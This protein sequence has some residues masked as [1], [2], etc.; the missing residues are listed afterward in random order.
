[1]N[2]A[3]IDPA[4][5]TPPPGPPVRVV[6]DI[7]DLPAAERRRIEPLRGAFARWV[8]APVD[9]RYKALIDAMPNR[10]NEFGYDEMGFN[11]EVLKWGL[12]F[13]EFIY[14]HYFRVELSG[15]E[16]IPAGRCL[17][18]CNHSGQVPIDGLMIGCGLAVDGKPPRAIRAMVERWVPNLPYVNILF[19]RVGAILGTP[20]NCRIL[21]QNDETILVFPEGVRG[22]SKL[23]WQRYQLAPFGLGFMRLALE[24]D[25]PIVPACV[26][27]AEEQYP[28]VLNLSTLGRWL[29]APALPVTVGMLLGGPLGAL[30]LPTKYRI[31]FGEPMRFDGDA[32]DEDVVIERKVREVKSRVRG[33]ITYGLKTRRSWFR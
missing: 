1:M 28:T 22:I 5:F 7:R 13:V 32:G 19:S 15:Q 24:N 9:R 26:I 16:N 4:A 17:I 10:L 20:E 33:M 23:W 21:L 31:Y 18:I 30:P 3:P 8:N 29:G 12:L 2:I 27:G 14:R 25:A 6:D 11:P